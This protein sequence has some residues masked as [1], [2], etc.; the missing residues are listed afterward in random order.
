MV[1]M[2]RGEEDDKVLIKQPELIKVHWNIIIHDTARNLIS[3]IVAES[4]EGER[5]A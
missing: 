2:E 4:I 1:T 5:A 3:A